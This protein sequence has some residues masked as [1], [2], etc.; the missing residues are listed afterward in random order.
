MRTSW[1][2]THLDR[3]SEK[4]LA[5]RLMIKR[6]FAVEDGSSHT[7]WDCYCSILLLPLGSY[8]HYISRRYCKHTSNWDC[9]S[10]RLREISYLQPRFKRLFP[11]SQHIFMVTQLIKRRRENKIPLCLSFPDERVIISVEHCAETHQRDQR[12]RSSAQVYQ[13][14]L[15]TEVTL[16]DESIKVVADTGVKQEGICSPISCALNGAFWKKITER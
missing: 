5:V 6:I 10:N 4:P 14:G 3:S 16:T 1:Q 11:T 15:L 9:L 13:E 12:D 2:T 7:Y 8:K